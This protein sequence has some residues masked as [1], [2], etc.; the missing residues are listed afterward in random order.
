MKKI[1]L[2]EDD[3]V[4]RE[5]TSEILE[6]AGYAVTVA[7]DGKEGAEAAKKIVP[8]LIVCDIMMP[9]LDGYGVLHILTKD[10]QTAAI[11]FIFLTAKAEK[12][13]WRK[14][15][16]LGAD[17]YLTKPFEETELLQAIE[18]RLKKNDMAKRMYAQGI[19]DL[20]QFLNQ[21][22]GLKELTAL[23]KK[24]PVFSHKKRETL[25]HEGDAPQFL[26][27]LIKGK[28][29]THKVNDEGKE[30][31]TTLAKPGDFVGYIPLLQETEYVDTAVVLEDCEVCK[32]PKD[33]FLSLIY[34][35]KDVAAQFMKL[36]A[37]NVADKEGQ[38]MSLAYDTVRKKVAGALLRLETRY[39]EKG[40]KNF[41][42]TIPRD[43][44]AGIA[45][46]ATETVI[47]SLSEFKDKGFIQIEGREIVV[48]D[49]QSLR[50]VF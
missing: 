11:P 1:L 10:P 16:D 13:E 22:D 27:F 48:L 24:H 25:F 38:L 39:R 28:V 40:Q 32:I 3:V 46:I 35:N 6:L 19:G 33:D 26:Y 36:L 37:G 43:D 49:S 23:S 4:V 47:R 44:L 5:N 17:D 7:K 50:E 42:I 45:G 31:V 9:H 18:V 14:G 34:A 2:I 21:A 15:M 30:L 8:D 20:G 12:N 41:K 29:R